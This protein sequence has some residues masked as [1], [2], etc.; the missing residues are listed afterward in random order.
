M[1]EAGLLLFVYS[2]L[3]RE[4]C[5]SPFFLVLDMGCYAYLPAYLLR[6]R[7]GLGGGRP[8]AIG[9][10]LPSVHEAQDINAD[11]LRE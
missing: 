1:N 11:H 5:R 2:T 8:F 7:G 10:R 3:V 6:G 9:S 4:Y